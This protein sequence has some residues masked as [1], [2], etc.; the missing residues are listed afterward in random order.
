MQNLPISKNP[1]QDVEA[2]DE[3]M[4]LQTDTGR[5]A[6]IGLWVLGLGF[7][8]FLVWATVAPMDEGVPTDRKSVV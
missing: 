3:G 1:I 4:K 8:G 7:G 2:I 5:V 6:R